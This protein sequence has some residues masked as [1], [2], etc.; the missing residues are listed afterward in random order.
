MKKSVLIT[1]A[2]RGIGL[3]LVKQY[4]SQGWLVH[5]TSRTLETAV[6]LQ[7]LASHNAD[8]IIHSLDVTNYEQLDQLATRLPSLDLVINN[9]GY[10]GP[11]GYGFGQTDV[12]EW[13][14]VFEINTIAP[15]KLIESLYSLLKSGT[16]KKIACISSKVGS[17]EEN[18]S[19]G[20]YI[21]RSSKA[22]LNS[23]VKSLSNDLRD[24]GFTVIALHPGWV[25][26]EMGGPNALIDIETSAKGL[27]D[28][29]EHTSVNH[30]GEFINY[31]GTRIAW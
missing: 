10:Y 8:L 24:E 26:T 13:R 12:E 6:D 23:V 16:T 14:R 5:A 30:S 20:G 17:M 29:I 9:A 28:V 2:N 3:G 27:F 22:A 19:G 4:L 7:D 21:Y 1:G 25:Q 31:D 11:K 15:L 18:T